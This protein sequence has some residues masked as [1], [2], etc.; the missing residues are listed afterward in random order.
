[1]R[2]TIIQGDCLE[3]LKTLESESVNCVMTSPPYNKGFYNKG[4]KPWR[5]DTW[6]QRRIEYGNFKDDLLP[7]EYD[8]Q[9]TQILEEL[10]RIIK[11]DGSIF[12]NHKQQFHNHKVIF[13]T[14]VFNF[15]IRQIIIWERGSSP[16]L[17]PIRWIPNTE[18][19]FWIT[20][21]NIQPKFHRF[22]EKFD[23]WHITPK[24][25]KEHPAPFPE[26]LVANCILST[27]DRGDIVFDPYMGSGTTALVAKKNGINYLGIELNP[28]YIKIAEKRLA[29]EV[30]I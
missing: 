14:F 7:E 24:P 15:N 20:K 3:V 27:C 29:Q 23:V 5:G 12:Y 8:K 18:Y 28:E 11:P 10:V 13:P 21:S 26:E 19:I 9:Q 17:S 16:Q 30:L 6:K 22:G 2:N 1:M 4:K 25:M